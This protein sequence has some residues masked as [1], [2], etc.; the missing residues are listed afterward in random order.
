MK[1][2]KGNADKIIVKVA[3]A[4]GSQLR[5]DQ[6]I[7]QMRTTISAGYETV[8]AIVAVSIGRPFLE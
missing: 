2:R 7:D 4:S 5:E 3:E 8:S 1:G 6:V